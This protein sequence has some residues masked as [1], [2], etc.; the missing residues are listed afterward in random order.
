MVSK[1][2]GAFSCVAAATRDRDASLESPCTTAIA[3]ESSFAFSAKALETRAR[4]ST[5]A[6]KHDQESGAKPQAPS[7]PQSRHQKS[8]ARPRKSKPQNKTLQTKRP[9]QPLRSSL[10]EHNN[11]TSVGQ[12]WLP[13][14]GKHSSCNHP[15]ACDRRS[16]QDRLYIT[17]LAARHAIRICCRSAILHIARSSLATRRKPTIKKSA[18]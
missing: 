7:C 9:D 18:P 10:L 4:T 1:A 3:S 8:T 16:K 5:Q 12:R 11:P 14:P 13:A 15:G 6:H 2:Q 17:P